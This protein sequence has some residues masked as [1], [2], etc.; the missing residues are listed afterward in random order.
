MTLVVT[1][2]FSELFVVACC[3]ESHG[4]AVAAAPCQ[5]AYLDYPSVDFAFEVYPPFVRGLGKDRV[6]WTSP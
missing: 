5:G 1:Q 3:Q 2:H 6:A 4:F